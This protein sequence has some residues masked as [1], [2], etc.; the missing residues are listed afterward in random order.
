[1]LDYGNIKFV[2][3]TTPKLLQGVHRLRYDVYVNEYHFEKAEDHPSGLEKDEWDPMSLHMAAVDAEENV[4]G[5]IRLVLNSPHGL[6]TLHA[7]TPFY[8]EPHPSSPRI[9]EVSRLAVARDFR[10]RVEDGF[11][12]VDDL[13]EAAPGSRFHRAEKGEFNS[14]DRR[15]Q[16]AVILGLFKIMYHVSKRIN[17]AD[18]YMVSE[19]RLW[20]LL[21]RYHIL[22]HPVGPEMEYHGVRI[23]YIG[24]ISE[25]ENHMLKVNQSLAES[26]IEGLDQSA[27]EGKAT[28]P[29]PPPEVKPREVFETVPDIVWPYR[30]PQSPPVVPTATD[31]GLDLSS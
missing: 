9:A 10:R 20:Y 15:R 13:A 16:F 5:T 18:W 3:A 30:I 8:Q 21:K 4:V 23:P 29:V 28:C 6:P 12:G 2:V 14:Q 1:M 31:L 25:I 22:F 27:D 17:L 11:R 7:V 19:K 24:H 26:F